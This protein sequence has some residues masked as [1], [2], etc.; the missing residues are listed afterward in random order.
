MHNPSGFTLLTDEKYINDFLELFK[1]DKDVTSKNLQYAFS[2]QSTKDEKTGKIKI[3]RP[4]YYTTDEF[5]LKKGILPNVKVDIQTTLGL[6]IYNLFCI[7]SVFGDL[8]DYVNPKIGINTDETKKIM[9]KLVDLVLLE[10]ISGKDFA[11]FQ[12][13]VSFLGYKGTLFTPGQSFEFVKVN[14]AVAKAKPILIKK[15]KE[16]VENG[17]DPTLSYIMMV[18]KPLLDIAKEN[19]KNNEAWPIYARGGKPQFGNM[20]KNCSVSVG[21]VYN[22]T[23][24]TYSIA[25]NSLMDGVPNESIPLFANIQI[26]AAYSRAVGTQDG[27]GKTKLLFSGLQST[28]LGE[29]GSNCGSKRYIEKVITESNIRTNVFRYIVD[30]EEKKI[31]KL[32]MDNYKKYLNKKVKMRSPLFCIGENFCNV[33]AGDYFYRM[34]IQNVGNTSTRATSTMMNKSLK[35]MHDVSLNVAKVDIFKYIVED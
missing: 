21:P 24:G 10:K 22:P 32:T 25:E 1:T 18:E 17:A 13:R 4:R 33:C 16:A 26:S 8:I 19:L 34:N 27:G 23:T 3:S 11:K 9:K 12:D 30:E 7:S 20:Y 2:N 28:I 6:Y 35:A 14:P 31:V 15:W 5:V 29:R